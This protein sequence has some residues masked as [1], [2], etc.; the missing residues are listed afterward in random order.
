MAKKQKEEKNNEVT[1]PK[2]KPELYWEWR[3][4]IS[5]MDKAKKEFDIHFL[6]HEMMI[7]D[8]EIAR[9]K[10]ALYKANLN[11]Y[12][13][14]SNLAKKEYDS[15]KKRIEEEI[16]MSLN[17]TVIDDFSFEVKKLNKS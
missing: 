8:I 2:L 10:T 7:K 3:C 13:E 17:D 12:E 9:L 1:N 4:T 15:M 16:G 14:A 5:E 6:K 11:M